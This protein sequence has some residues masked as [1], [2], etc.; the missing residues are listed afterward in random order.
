VTD[1]VLIRRHYDSPL[2]QL[3]LVASERGLRAVLWPNDQPAR[4]PLPALVTGASPVLDEACAQLDA[5]FAARRTTFDV[6]FD[7]IGTAFQ[8]AA[9]LALAT[10]PYGTTRSYAQQATA[11]GRPTAARAVG[12]ANGRNPLSIV[13]PCHRVIG[14]NGALTGFAGGIDAKRWLLEFERDHRPA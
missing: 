13:L 5:W 2:G 10:I 8:V 4:V 7:L 6:P 12:A 3:A 1:S 14:A 9:W 11:L